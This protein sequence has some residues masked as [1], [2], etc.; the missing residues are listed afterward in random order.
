MSRWHKIGIGLV[1]GAVL[2]VALGFWALTGAKSFFYPLAPPMPAVVHEPMPDILARLQAILETNA[3]PVLA[4]LQPGLSATDI[5]K[6]EGQ[7]HVQLPEEIKAIYQWHD[8]AH[9]TANYVGNDFIPI[10]RFLPLEEALEENAVDSKGPA[11]L[12]QR[13]VYRV[14][15]G[16]RDSWICLF[17]DGAR[18]GYWFDL[19]RKPSEGE[20]FYTFTEDGTFVFFPS[21]KNLMAGV[22]KCYEQGIYRVK[23]GTSPPELDEDFDRATKVWNEFGASNQ[24]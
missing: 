7:Y 20:V 9:H 8:G 24:P 11:T 10:H 14:V 22:A 13:V 19:K 5:A 6:L 23:A 2:L 18:D 21:A 16:Q 15:A 4:G 3:P 12:V 1:A 17:S